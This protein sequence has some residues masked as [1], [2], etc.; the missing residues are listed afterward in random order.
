MISSSVRADLGMRCTNICSMRNASPESVQASAT[1]AHEQLPAAGVH[2]RNDRRAG[3]RAR[4]H[5]R[6]VRAHAVN[7]AGDCDDVASVELVPNATDVGRSG[8]ERAIGV[9]MGVGQR[10][11]LRHR[12][13]KRPLEAAFKNQD[14]FCDQSNCIS[15]V[16]MSGTE[17][18]L[19]KPEPVVSTMLATTKLPTTGASPSTVPDPLM[20]SLPP[21]M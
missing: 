21:T 2:R 5:D 1:V 15:G 11:W 16:G 10:H 4:R 9:D 14:C 8:A 18:T 3:H 20:L 6:D 17:P 7:L 13:R 12:Q 19:M